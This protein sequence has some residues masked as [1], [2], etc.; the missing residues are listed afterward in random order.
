ML[1]TVAPPLQVACPIA[2][3]S[4]AFLL[5]RKKQSEFVTHKWTRKCASAISISA[6]RCLGVCIVPAAVVYL[7]YDGV[8]AGKKY[9]SKFQ[10][11]YGKGRYSSHIDAAVSSTV[12]RRATAR[13]S[14]NGG[15]LRTFF[16]TVLLLL[17]GILTSTCVLYSI[18]GLYG[19]C[20]FSF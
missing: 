8:D 20:M 19:H 13:Q 10:Y 1:F 9:I 17:V 2:Y 12:V 14:Q 7:T 3:G 6:K 11:P 15:L 16:S 18:C 5:E 4:L